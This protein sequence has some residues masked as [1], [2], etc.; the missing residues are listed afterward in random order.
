MLGNVNGFDVVTD[1]FVRAV[2]LA[3]ES[4]G[5]GPADA[6]NFGLKWPESKIPRTKWYVSRCRN[7]DIVR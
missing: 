6:G 3:R 5:V 7:G 1:Q 2:A 4:R